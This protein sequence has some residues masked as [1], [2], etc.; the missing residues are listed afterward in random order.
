MGWGLLPPGCMRVSKVSLQCLCQIQPR[1]PSSCPFRCVIFCYRRIGD[2]QRFGIQCKDGHVAVSPNLCFSFGVRQSRT[3]CTEVL[4]Q[5][6]ADVM[7][8]WSTCSGPVETRTVALPRGGQGTCEKGS[9]STGTN[10]HRQLAA[11]GAS[12][13]TWCSGYYC[14]WPGHLQAILF[15][16]GWHSACQVP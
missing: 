13:P 11:S 2:C 7:C 3:F 12:T 14:P 5:R 10:K 16:R 15:R 4:P 8:E 9:G 1:C 6:L